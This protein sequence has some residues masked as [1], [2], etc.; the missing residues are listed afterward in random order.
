MHGTCNGVAGLTMV[1]LSLDR[2]NDLI[3]GAAGLAG[4]LA[5]LVVALCIFLFDRYVTRERLCTS[6]LK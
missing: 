4:I 3:D 6:K 2:Y 1:F 5:L